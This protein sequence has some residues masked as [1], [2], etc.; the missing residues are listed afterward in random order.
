MEDDAM[1]TTERRRNRSEVP[2]QALALYLAAVAARS[3]LKA[4]TLANEDGFLVAGTGGGYNLEWLA[5]LGPV[6]AASGPMNGAIETL[7]EN[8]TG[9]E[10]LYASAV[11]IGNDTLYLTSVGARVPRQKEA[12]EALGRILA[13]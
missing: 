1:T 13:N 11:K 4:L 10:D 8:V 3:S 5:A 2:E 6:C 12:A 7:V 9:G